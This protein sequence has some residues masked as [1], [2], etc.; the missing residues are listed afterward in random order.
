MQQ[1][2]IFDWM[3]TVMQEPEVGEII[4]EPGACIP[5]IMRSGYIGR[6]VCFDCSTQSR[7]A[8]RV[9]ILEAVNQS[10]YWHMEGDE[11]KQVPC[12][13]VVIFTGKKQRALI[14]LTPGREIHECLP[15]NAYPER[16]KAIYGKN[17]M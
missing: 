8:Y 14:S 2:T 4:R 3:P 9:G 16:M 7:K 10:Y 12:D 13:R 6:K 5:H 1:L 17:D 15:W 11:Y